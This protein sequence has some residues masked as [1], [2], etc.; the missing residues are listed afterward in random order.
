VL[1]SPFLEFTSLSSSDALSFD[2]GT[3]VKDLKSHNPAIA[4]SEL[5]QRHDTAFAIWTCLA[6]L[7]C[8]PTLLR[9]AALMM[10]VPLVGTGCATGSGGG[11]PV[12]TYPY[13][14]EPPSIPFEPICLFG[15]EFRYGGEFQ[16]CR[17]SM[18]NFTQALTD[19]GN[20]QS[21]VVKGIFN[22]LIQASVDT[23]N[24]YVTFFSDKSDLERHD[25]STS[26]PPVDVPNRSMRTALE[27]DGIEYDFGVPDCVAKAPGFSG[28]PQ[29]AF[30][31]DECKEAVDQ[32]AGNGSS[33]RVSLGSSSAQEQYDQYMDN[34]WYELRRK[35]RDAVEKFNC[36]AEGRAI[37]L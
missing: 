29:T 7:R 10:I 21:T 22:E 12:A 9:F 18:E 37:C 6:K 23:Y 28:A 13:G 11:W 31:L 2:G 27:A 15:S 25:P 1:A 17:T 35:S 32:F 3:D 26:C 36:L 34:L 14:C 20:C 19:F 30:D 4:S 24:C 33:Y 5:S 16:A 8:I